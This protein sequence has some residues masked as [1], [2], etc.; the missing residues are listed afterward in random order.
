MNEL[1]PT[2]G[3]VVLT[4]GNRP[5]QLKAALS[6][7]LGQVDVEVDVVVVGNGWL[8]TDLPAGVKSVHSKE[9]L[10]IPAGRN[11]GVSNVKGDLLFFLDDDVVLEDN[12]TLSRIYKKFIGMPKVALIQPQPKDPNG[13]ATPRR[14]IPRLNTKNPDRPSHIFA[15]WE[16]ATTVRRDVFEKVGSWPNEFFYGHEGV[17]L[18]WR[19]WDAGFKCWYAGDVVVSH[20]AVEPETRHKIYYQY[21]AR[22]RV[23]LARRNLP[24][25]ISYWYLLNWKV[26]SLFRLRSNSEGKKEFKKG[27]Q[28]GKSADISPQKKLSWF[29]VLKM[30]LFLRPPII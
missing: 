4:Q 9:N 11:L 15:L 22:N 24:G 5:M 16:G 20:P 14:W 29:T 6:S 18:V 3:C 17:D 10:G 2:F 12:D 21:Q 7:L 13:L 28:E 1:K 27:W 30:T 8:P 25:F 23:I 19:I 26:I